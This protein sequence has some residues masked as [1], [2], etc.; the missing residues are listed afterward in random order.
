MLTS[1]NEVGTRSSWSPSGWSRSADQSAGWPA[2][3]TVAGSGMDDAE[4]A[5]SLGERL[6]RVEA[7]LDE[8]RA[9]G[10]HTIGEREHRFRLRPPLSEQQVA[11]FE[12]RNGARLPDDY[13]LFVTRL[14][15]GGAGPYYGVEPLDPA[16]R[17]LQLAAPYLFGPDDLCASYGAVDLG[18]L[19]WRHEL[20]QNDHRDG[21]WEETSGALWLCRQGKAEWSYHDEGEPWTLLV[22]NGPG[23]GRLVTVEREGARFAPI[24]LPARDFLA[25]YEEWL[26]RR[27][28]PEYRLGWENDLERPGRCAST[29]R[30]H[31]DEEEAL[32]AARTIVAQAGRWE[33]EVRGIPDSQCEILAAVAAGP[34]CPRVRAA[35]VWALCGAARSVDA[36]ALVTPLLADPA[37]AVRLQAVRTLRSLRDHAR[38]YGAGDQWWLEQPNATVSEAIRPLLDDHDAMVRAEVHA[39]LGERSVEIV[40]GLLGDRAPEVRIRGLT[41]VSDTG[42][43]LR[44]ELHEYVRGGL[45]DPQPEVRAAA[46]YAL[47]AV[48]EEW[49][50]G[51]LAEAATTDPDATVR[52]SAARTLLDTCHPAPTLEIMLLLLRDAT[53]AVRYEALVRLLDAP[54]DGDWASAVRACL[55]DPDPRIRECAISVLDRADVPVTDEQW[56]ELLADPDSRPRMRALLAVGDLH[57]SAGE[58]LHEAVHRRLHDP[59]RDIRFRAAF[60]LEA[61][62]SESCRAMLRN[63]HEAETD[64]VIRFV[65]DKILTRLN[66]VDPVDG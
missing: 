9:D 58:P 40:S 17:G 24:Y 7:K 43:E 49:A 55:T 12:E 31:A 23:R 5:E 62:C 32:W 56:V 38:F 16:A 18:S 20:L 57:P 21:Y 1:T 6:V 34:R 30:D 63:E 50:I 45:S 22:V 65:I 41:A 14:G 27:G 3:L 29:V 52:L 46:A 13:R 15:N 8:A 2:E 33:I 35:A 51:R 28:A 25:W 44:P 60:L 37:A 64:S 48:R 66:G 59:D 54:P 42:T 4:V 11:A 10:L 36:T 39:C 19:A 53:A 61:R 26:D 47:G